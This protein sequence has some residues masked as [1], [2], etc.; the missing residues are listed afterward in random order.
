MFVD[1]IDRVAPAKPASR[2]QSADNYNC[3][4]PFPAAADVAIAVT[5]E[6]CGTPVR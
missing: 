3:S 1:D 2:W 4:H 6:T 5:P